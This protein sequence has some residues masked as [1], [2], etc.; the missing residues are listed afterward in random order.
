MKF[1]AFILGICAG[2]RVH[3]PGNESIINGQ[4]RDSKRVVYLTV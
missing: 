3:R 4:I 2:R 1:G